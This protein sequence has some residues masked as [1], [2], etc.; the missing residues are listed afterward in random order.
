MLYVLRM[1]FKFTVLP[2][3][4]ALKS[5]NYKKEK[6]NISYFNIGKTK[7]QLEPYI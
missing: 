3:Q 2:R 6:I 4:L 7:L 1:R 5:D